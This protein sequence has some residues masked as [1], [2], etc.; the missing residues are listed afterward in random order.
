MKK[1]QEVGRT[2]STGLAGGDHLHFTMLVQGVPVNP[3]EWWD[4]HWLQDRVFRKISEAG[5][6]ASA[7]TTAAAEP[8]AKPARAAKSAARRRKR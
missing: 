6:P 4:A 7:V 1:D 8:A 2:G 3:V 5:G